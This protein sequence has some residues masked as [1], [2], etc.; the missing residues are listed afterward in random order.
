MFV[1]ANNTLAAAQVI[2]MDMTQTPPTQKVIDTV[3]PGH[4]FELP[5]A[6]SPTSCYLL[7]PPAMA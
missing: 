6:V 7:Q 2:E 5:N 4:C 3:E 1:L